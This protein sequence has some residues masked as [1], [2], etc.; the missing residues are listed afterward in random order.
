MGRS[1]P[2]SPGFGV[3]LCDMMI[4]GN[5]MPKTTA[6]RFWEKV[7]KTEYCWEWTGS[8]RHK[9]YGAFCYVKNGEPVQGRAHRFSYELHIGPIPEGLFVL[10][11]CDNP[12]CVNPDH[13]FVGDNRANVADMISKGRRVKGGTY[14]RDG[15][16]SGNYERGVHHHNA[17]I[18]PDIV[19][20]IRKDRDNGLSFGGI[21]A[22]YG[23]SISHAFRIV[24][25]SVWS[26]VE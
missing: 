26:H 8:K 13:L 11:K 17:K 20:A 23:L 4:Q 7:R 12:K 18:T 24:N 25:R 2:R 1:K 5:A 6:D 10:H 14:C 9:G 15:Y 22:K 21:A 16:G 3:G 19:I